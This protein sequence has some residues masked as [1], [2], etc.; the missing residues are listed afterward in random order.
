MILRPY[1]QARENLRFRVE[2]PLELNGKWLDF[3]NF[4][5]QVKTHKNRQALNA[6]R[7]ARLQLATHLNDLEQATQMTNQLVW[8]SMKSLGPSVDYCVAHFFMG[9]N[10]FMLART[11]WNPLYRF[12]ARNILRRTARWVKDGAVNEACRLM[13][14]QAENTA[15]KGG[16][17]VKEAYETAISSCARAGNK[18]LQALAY[19]RAGQYFIEHTQKI[20]MGKHFITRAYVVY[21]EWGGE[22][23][24]A[25]LEKKYDFLRRDTMSRD[26]SVA[27]SGSGTY[28]KSVERFRS[29]VA[30][31]HLRVTSPW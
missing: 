27:S 7:I 23:V 29:K 8:I 30:E 11:R 22:G 9:L 6:S 14:L 20:E 25:Y 31:T 19:Q 1:T 13:I 4:M 17:I 26:G 15:L 18:Q 2:K 5:K 21:N 28:H 10:R 16:D 24:M 3:D 12:Q